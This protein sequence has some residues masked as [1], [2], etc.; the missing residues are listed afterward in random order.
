MKR[1]YTIWAGKPL[2]DQPAT[3]G[4]PA[5]TGRHAQTFRRTITGTMRD[6][7]AIAYSV[8]DDDLHALVTVDRYDGFDNLLREHKTTRVAKRIAGA[9]VI[10]EDLVALSDEVAKQVRLAAAGAS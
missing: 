8:P 10:G 9:W 3:P 6:A 4:R 1:R 5:A 2:A 7:M